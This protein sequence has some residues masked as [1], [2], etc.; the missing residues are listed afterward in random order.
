MTNM[1]GAT[2]HI[3]YTLLGAMHIFI[4]DTSASGAACVHLVSV[5]PY[6]LIHT[7]GHP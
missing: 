5:Q 2:A 4:I 1:E 6:H 3:T 7:K